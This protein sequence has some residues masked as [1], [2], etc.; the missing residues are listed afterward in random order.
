MV[1]VNG[2]KLSAEALGTLNF[3]AAADRLYSAA[4]PTSTTSFSACWWVRRK[5]GNG[6]GA[7]I[8]FELDGAGYTAAFGTNSQAITLYNGGGGF[9]RPFGNGPTMT[10]DKWYFV[11]F[12]ATAATTG[13]FYWGDET[14]GVASIGSGARG[15]TLSTLSAT[16]IGASAYGFAPVVDMGRVRIWNAQLTLAELETERLSPN[17]A[18]RTTN[19]SADWQLKD[20]ATKLVDSSGNANSLTAAGVGPWTD[21]ASAPNPV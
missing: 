14:T 4:I 13:A 2:W 9:V 20:G 7:I 12:V 1:L 21:V 8:F 3:D 6:S 5:S 19:L 15:F 17:L 10:V 16:S 11:A 18:S